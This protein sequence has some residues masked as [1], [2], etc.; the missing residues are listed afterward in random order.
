[1]KYILDE[2]DKKILE[3]LQENAKT[4]IRE[5]ASHLNLSTTPIF[6]RIK[7]LEKNGVISKQV[8]LLDESKIGKA[9][10]SFVQVSIKD[11][12]LSMVREFTK[13]ITSFEEVMEC[14]HISGDA[15]F[16]IKVVVDDMSEFNQFLLNKI[17]KV[18][19]IGRHK[20][21][22]ALSCSKHTTA[23]KIS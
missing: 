17:S 11:H 9:M 5:L 4:T 3:L 2:T 12:S 1:M 10:T 6:D 16:L 7:R 22:F 23:Y 13:K 15:D 14:Y 8:V 19:N 20:T 18:P 21:Q